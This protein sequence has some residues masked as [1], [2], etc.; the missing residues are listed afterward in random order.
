LNNAN[1]RTSASSLSDTLISTPISPLL[2]S[3]LGRDESVLCD[4]PLPVLLLMLPET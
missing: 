4:V 1:H 2:H 3:S